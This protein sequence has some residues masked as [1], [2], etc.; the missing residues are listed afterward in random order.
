MRDGLLP[1]M[2]EAVQRRP[3]TRP[4]RVGRSRSRWSRAT[5]PIRP[6]DLVARVE[7][8]AAGARGAGRRRRRCRQPDDRHAAVGRLARRRQPPAPGATVVDLDATESIAE[9]WLG[10]RHLPGDGR[11]PGVARTRRSATPTS[12]TLRRHRGAGAAYPRAARPGGVGTAAAARVHQ[13]EHL[14]ERAQRARLAVLDGGRQG[15]RPT[16]R[17]ADVAATRASWRR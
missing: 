3:T 17:V 6:T 4:R 1:E 16:S 13:P 12:S 8:A 11:V 5:R 7:G 14:D 10:H 2:A 15:A 9:T